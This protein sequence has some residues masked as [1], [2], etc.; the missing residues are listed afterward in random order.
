MPRSHSADSFLHI[1]LWFIVQ[2]C[3]VE[4][5]ANRDGKVVARQN[6][7]VLDVFLDGTQ[8]HRLLHDLEIVG[9]VQRHWIHGRHERIGVFVVLRI[10]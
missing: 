4:H 5:L 7:V 1:V 2:K 8:I 3:V 10:S 9:N 6:H